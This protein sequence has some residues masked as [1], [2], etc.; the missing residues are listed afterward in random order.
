M[1]AAGQVDTVQVSGEL[2]ARASGNGVVD[3][4]WRHG[5]LRY[6]AQVVHVRGQGRR[7]AAE[8]AASSDAPVVRTAPSSHLTTLQPGLQVTRDQWRSGGGQLLGF[9]VPSALTITAFLLFV[10]GLGLL[11]A[12]PSRGAPTGGRGS[13]C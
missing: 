7:L 13:G 12:G 10:T 9:Q 3:V 8:A 2:P 6:T 4:H 1:V 11:I 5:W